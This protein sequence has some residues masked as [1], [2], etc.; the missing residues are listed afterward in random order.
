MGVE[1]P[2]AGQLD[3]LLLLWLEPAMP[4]EGEIVGHVQHLPGRSLRTDARDPN[5]L[6]G[7]VT[8]VP[9]KRLDDPRRDGVRGI[10]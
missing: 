2:T 1:E 6:N 5:R 8:P 10:R 7:R 3:R 9:Q 4:H